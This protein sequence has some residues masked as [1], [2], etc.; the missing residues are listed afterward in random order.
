MVRTGVLEDLYRRNEAALEA[1]DARIR[2][3]EN[4]VLR[5][6]G[7][8]QPMDAVAAELAALYPT[9]RSLMY[10]RAV[11]VNASSQA[12]DSVPTVLATW[13]RLP[14]PA[15]RTRIHRFLGERL[16]IDSVR[17]QHLPAR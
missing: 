12:V 4:E 5:L 10:G 11:R 6:R 7:T 14:A 8:E 2:V 13:T 15:D 16:K 1:R 9:L 3:L 17:V